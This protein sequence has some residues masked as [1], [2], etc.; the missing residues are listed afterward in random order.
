MNEMKTSVCSAGAPL[1]ECCWL[2]VYL[3]AIVLAWD[4]VQYDFGYMKCGWGGVL[5]PVCY[6][7]AQVVIGS[8]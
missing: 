2:L 3:F 4:V 8:C 6:S 1:H 7:V 5:T